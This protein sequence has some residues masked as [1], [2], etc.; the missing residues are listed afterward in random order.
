[1]E[2]KK[3]ANIYNGKSQGK[4]IKYLKIQSRNLI[5]YK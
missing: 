1:M 2:F 4:K 5:H 3:K